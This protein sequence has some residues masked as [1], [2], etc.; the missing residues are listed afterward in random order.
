MEHAAVGIF[1]R[2]GA[3]ERLGV[4]LGEH[5]DTTVFPRLVGSV[6]VVDLQL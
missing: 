4:W 5:V 6:G 3:A 2:E 1:E